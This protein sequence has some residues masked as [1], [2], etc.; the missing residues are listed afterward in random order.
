[1]VEDEGV[2]ACTTVDS[3]LAEHAAEHPNI[4]IPASNKPSSGLPHVGGGVSVEAPARETH[5]ARARRSSGETAEEKSARVQARLTEIYETKVRMEA[6][7]VAPAPPIDPRTSEQRI[8]EMWA[9]YESKRDAARLRSRE[10]GQE[11]ERADEMRETGDVGFSTAR[12]AIERVE[13]RIR[14]AATTSFHRYTLLSDERVVARLEVEQLSTQLAEEKAENQEWRTRIEAKEVEWEKKLKDMVAAVERLSATKVVDWT[15]Q[16]RY[17]IQGERMHGLLGQGGTVEPPQQKKIKKVFLD[18]AEAEAKRIT[19]GKSFSFKAPTWLATQQATPMSVEAPA[20]EPTQRPQS[21]PAEEGSAKE[22]HTILLEVRGGT[23]TGA[24]A[25]TEPET[26][27]EETSRLDELV[28]AMEIDMPLDRPQRLDTLE[29][30]PESV[31]AQSSE[32]ARVAESEPQGCMGLPLCCEG[33]AEAE[34][35]PSISNP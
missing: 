35:T 26:V 27:E 9:R 25:P 2:G 20:G 4:E 19:E 5:E 30:R 24:V 7:G 32:G 17:G 14:Q 10:T 18:P 28:T 31:G 29:Y 22:F 1:M 13:R 23:L 6:V 15:E 16:S 11:Y 33:A 8:D 21:P 34:G 3:R 12:M